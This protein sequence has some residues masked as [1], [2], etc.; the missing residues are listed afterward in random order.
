V[1]NGIRGYLSNAQLRTLGL[2]VVAPPDDAT[3]ELTEADVVSMADWST[4]QY[5]D[6]RPLRAVLRVVTTSSA[7]RRVN[8]E[9]RPAVDHE[10]VWVL[11]APDIKVFVSGPAKLY[12]GQRVPEAPEL[13]GY[14]VDL[15]DADTG[16]NLKGQQLSTAT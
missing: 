7:G 11:I 15:I 2:V 12:D 6:A 3:S 4:T 13:R 14:E 8:G 16:E 5:A 1:D 9:F 10:L